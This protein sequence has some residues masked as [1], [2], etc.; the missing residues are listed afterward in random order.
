MQHRP[1]PAFY[2]IIGAWKIPILALVV[3]LKPWWNTPEIGFAIGLVLAGLGL[4][5][6][7]ARG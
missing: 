1:W 7:L 3:D 4:F 6:K 2:G 5:F